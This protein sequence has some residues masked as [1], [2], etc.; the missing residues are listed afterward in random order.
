VRWDDILE[1]AAR[2]PMW[3]RIPRGLLAFMDFIAGGA[4]WGY[5]RTNW[6][7]ALFFL[8]PYLL[9][10]G[11]AALAALAGALAAQALAS[12]M[13]GIAAGVLILAVLLRWP[14]R[15]LYLPL[16]FDDW[17]FARICVRRG[18]PVLEARLDRAAG[19]IVAAARR[20][21]VDEV[22]IVGHSLGAV[23]AVDLVDRAL[24][25]DPGLGESGSRV[26]LLTVGSSI[27]K[28]GLHRDARRFRAALQRV[29]AATGVFW[30]EYQALLDVMNFYKTDPIE[31][32]GLTPTGR[33]VIRIVRLSRMLD[34][35]FYRRIKRN[36]FRLHRQFVSGN[37]RRATYDYFM[38]VCGPLPAERQFRLPE[39]PGSAIAPDGALLEPTGDG[40]SMADPATHK[41]GP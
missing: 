14:G 10:A 27:P 7:Y 6:R 29:A 30:A 37:D 20:D 2:E 17:I 41:A 12:T 33:P 35:D 24:R 39:G 1:T 22:L 34:P 32:L 38:L 26:A 40:D 18:H 3:R 36:F 5:F 15:R 16:M 19:N 28:I 11:L 31:A 8:Y 13:A 21:D 23:L 25:V 4:L 9:F